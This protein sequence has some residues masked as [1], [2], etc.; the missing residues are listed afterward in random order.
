MLLGGVVIATMFVVIQAILFNLDYY[1]FNF[2]TE[3]ITTNLFMML[4]ASI[5]VV[6][7]FLSYVIKIYELRNCEKEIAILKK[8]AFKDSLTNLDNRESG[9]RVL[10]NLVEY[11]IPYYLIIF[12]LNNLKKANDEYGHKRGDKLIKDFADCLN[13]AF[14]DNKC[15]NIRYGGDEFLVILR[16]YTDD[17]V[18]KQLKSLKHYI[19]KANFKNRSVDDVTLSVAYGI[20]S[21]TEI[22]ENNY[23]PV[24][25]LADKRMY[26]N[27]LEMKKV[28]TINQ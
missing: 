2:S 15:E 22:K 21:S 27:K 17:D 13:L 12:D 24:L 28:V 8:Y 11:K 3:I 19:D 5:L 20:A 10:K 16:S 1:L 25:E 14:P 18:K 9:T 26:K 4:A 6:S 7:L 23:T